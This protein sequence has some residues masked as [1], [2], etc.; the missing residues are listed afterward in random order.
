MTFPY[1]RKYISVHWI[2]ILLQ[3]KR[4]SIA[5]NIILL[6]FTSGYASLMACVSL[7]NCKVDFNEILLST[8]ILFLLNN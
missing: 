8:N 3:L 1:E 2:C 6:T 7:F 5:A 4:N